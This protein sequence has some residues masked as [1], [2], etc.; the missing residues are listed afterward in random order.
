MQK[1]ILTLAA[2]ALC[3]AALTGCEAMPRDRYIQWVA[4]DAWSAQCAEKAIVET[5]KVE[6]RRWKVKGE[7]LLADIDAT[8]KLTDDCAGMKAY[9]SK[10]FSVKGFEISKCE[11][12]GKTGWALPGKEKKRCWTGPQLLPEQL[13]P[14]TPAQQ[15]MKDKPAPARPS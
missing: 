5:W 14:E 9:E 4:R 13:Q 15:R 1:S 11:V 8:F 7:S 10:R 6:N 2:G 12:G 3:A